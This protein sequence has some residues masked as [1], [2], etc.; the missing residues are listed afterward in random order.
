MRS[1]KNF[2]LFSSLGCE[3]WTVDVDDGVGVDGH[4]VGEDEL[5]LVLVP[6]ADGAGMDGISATFFLLVG[7]EMG[8]GHRW[9]FLDV[10][11]E[12]GEFVVEDSA[13][14][15]REFYLAVGESCRLADGCSMSCECCKGCELGGSLI[16]R[17][18][19][20]VLRCVMGQVYYLVV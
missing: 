18:P 9:A 10:L 4:A 15:V 8:D 2:S 19:G 1:D 6:L 7:N 11:D 5:V 16:H 20:M 3:E 17:H 13:L 12:Q 14:L